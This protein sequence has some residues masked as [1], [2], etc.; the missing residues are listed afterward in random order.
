MDASDLEDMVVEAP[1]LFVASSTH[2]W[3]LQAVVDDGDALNLDLTTNKAN[4]LPR[5]ECPDDLL[6]LDQPFGL[7]LHPSRDLVA[8]GLVSGVVSVFSYRMDANV[9]VLDGLQNPTHQAAARCVRS[10]LLL[11][12]AHVTHHFNNRSVSTQLADTF[13]VQ[14]QT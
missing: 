1:I 4:A 5:D 9:C 8:V 13:I 6:F 2:D 14:E 11:S 12:F 10:R 7:D 3:S